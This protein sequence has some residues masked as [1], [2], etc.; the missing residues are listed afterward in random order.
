MTRP[1][2]SALAKPG[3]PSAVFDGNDLVLTL[4]GSSSCPVIVASARL[5]GSTLRLTPAP[6]TSQMCTMDLGPHEQRVGLPAGASPDAIAAVVL[7]DP[8]GP[9]VQVELAR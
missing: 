8:A 4:W 5:E 7:E 1:T 3:T 6:P 9:D 2:D